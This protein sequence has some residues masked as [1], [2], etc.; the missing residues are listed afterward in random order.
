MKTEDLIK[1]IQGTFLE[2]ILLL[3]HTDYSEPTEVI[4]P[5]EIVVAEMNDL[6]KALFTLFTKRFESLSPYLIN[7]NGLF[8]DLSLNLGK[9]ENL[10]QAF[11]KEKI[12]EFEEM[13]SFR[14]ILLA[15]VGERLRNIRHF[16]FRKGF[17]IVSVSP[18]M[19]EA[20]IMA[21]WLFAKNQTFVN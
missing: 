1:F 5:G 12:M 20:A 3:H 18:K 8:K 19:R 21:N 16:S 11:T 14:M 2:E 9:I 10:G 6:E 17:K 7:L 4:G 15:L 13:K